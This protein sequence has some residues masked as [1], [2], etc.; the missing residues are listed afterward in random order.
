MT[1]LLEIDDSDEHGLFDFRKCTGQD[2][3]QYSLLSEIHLV[4]FACLNS[5]KNSLYLNTALSP[6][7]A[8]IS[9]DVWSFRC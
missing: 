8:S 5:S 3:P 9:I 1:S 6:I 4:C 7:E 2:S